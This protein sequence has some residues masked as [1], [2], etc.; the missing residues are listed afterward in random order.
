[1]AAPI[2]E[3]LA[4]CLLAAAPAA[5]DPDG[6]GFVE[7]LRHAG[8]VREA[9]AEVR[10][11]DRLDGAPDMTADRLLDLGLE[12]AS[13]GDLASAIE[14]VEMAIARTEDVAVGDDR[15]LVLGTLR[16]KQGS[17]PSAQRTFAKVIA[18]SASAGA[19][20][21]A[22]RLACIGSLWG[23]DPAPARAC[24]PARLPPSRGGAARRAAEGGRAGSAARSRSC[25]PAW[26]RRPPA[27][28]STDFSPSSSTRAAPPGRS[29]WASA[30]T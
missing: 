14:M 15:A 28:S 18:F 10:R 11:Q 30:A 8:L 22:E 19:R 13:R 21:R 26:A 1:M 27:S 4:S 5:P 29:R 25:C 23:L 12:L 17:Y 3:L 20:A 7:R 24:G 6:A 9:A 16:L 2:L